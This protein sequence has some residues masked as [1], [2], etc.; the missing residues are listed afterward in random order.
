MRT[1]STTINQKLRLVACA[2]LILAA[3][4]LIKPTTGTVT[5]GQ[6]YASPS[7]THPGI[8]IG[9]PIGTPVGSACKGIVIAA[10]DVGDGY[11]N[12]VIV[13]HNKKYLSRYAHLSAIDVRWGDTVRMGQDIGKVGQTGQVTG[14]HLHFAVYQ[15]DPIE[16]RIDTLPLIDL[17]PSFKVGEHITIGEVWGIEDGPDCED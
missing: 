8:D 6:T 13:A 12:Q 10:G 4:K 16:G 9:A 11:G 3:C 1:Q 7:G 2:A 17:N 5:Q 14:A 15:G